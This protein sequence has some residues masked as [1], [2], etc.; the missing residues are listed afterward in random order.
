[1]S[2]VG[3]VGGA[4]GGGAA[5]MP[6]A[7]GAEGGAAVTPAA[8]SPD[9]GDFSGGDGEVKSVGGGNDSSNTGAH[10]APMGCHG[11]HMS[12]QNFISLQNTSIQQVNQMDES[13]LDLKKLIEMMMAIKL[14]QELNKSQ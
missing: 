8:G 3:G 13:Q 4:G 5:S 6:T 10:V 9:S 1:M 7:G 12:T 2:G 14:L 11:N